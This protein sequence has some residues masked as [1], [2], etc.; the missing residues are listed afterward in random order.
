MN[1]LL[2]TL[3]AEDVGL[4]EPHLEPIVLD[5]R[6]ALERPKIPIEHIYFPTSGV[7]SIVAPVGRDQR[8][9]VGIVG[10]EGMTGSAVSLG[11]GR[12]PYE[13]FMQM[14]GDGLRITS[15]ALRE[16]MRESP[17]LQNVFLR[18]T[19]AL[20]IQTAQT[21]ASNARANLEDRLCRWLLMCH[22]RTDGDTLNLTHD[23]LA[24]M[25]GVRRAG[26]TLAIHL[27]EGRALIRA[28]RGCIEIIDREGMEVSANGIYGLPESEYERLIGISP[29]EWKS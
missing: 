22:D 10:R 18:Y 20:A 24:T 14:Q 26:V 27:L 7:A 4:I 29:R 25:L 13:C 19:Q 9:E 5:R 21:A 23:F 1:I 15:D 8:V 11:N 28:R 2:R 3:S 6:F 12:S 16:A 17:T